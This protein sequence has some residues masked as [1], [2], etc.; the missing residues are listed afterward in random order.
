MRGGR[1]GVTRQPH[2]PA[3]HPGHSHQAAGRGGGGGGGDGG[4]EADPGEAQDCQHQHCQ[5][6]PAGILTGTDSLAVI[7]EYHSKC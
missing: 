2:C 1:G 5:H 6:Q 7:S 3:Q 4:G